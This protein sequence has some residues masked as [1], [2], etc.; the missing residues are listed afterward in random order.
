MKAAF[1]VSEK[2]GSGPG[3]PT[4]KD[5]MKILDELSPPV[6]VL[7]I[8]ADTGEIMV[9]VEYN[10]PHMPSEIDAA[11]SKPGYQVTTVDWT[12]RSKM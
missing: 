6:N 2:I 5:I 11:L 4:E 3:I 1:R 8:T 12:I 9:T 7:S 10:A